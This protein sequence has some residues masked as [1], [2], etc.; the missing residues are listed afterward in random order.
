MNLSYT[1]KVFPS[2]LKVVF[3]RMKSPLVTLNLWARV[4]VKDEEPV[5]IGISH[6]F[7]HMVFKGTT[8]TQD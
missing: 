5:Q 4:G 7:E 3:R 1:K 6:F 8:N 2:D